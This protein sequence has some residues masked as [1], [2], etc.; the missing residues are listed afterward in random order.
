MEIWP[1][2]WHEHNDIKYQSPVNINTTNAYRI[3]LPK[4]NYEGYWA[5]EESEVIITNNGHTGIRSDN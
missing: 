4:L 1:Y 5:I 3:P 2:V